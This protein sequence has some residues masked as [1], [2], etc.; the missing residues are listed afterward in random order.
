MTLA[1]AVVV[2]LAGNAIAAGSAAW[3]VRIL[4]SLL[5]IAIA[6]KMFRHAAE[7]EKCGCTLHHEPKPTTNPIALGIAGGLI[8]CFGSLSLVT[9][10]VG[11]GQFFAAVPLVL[12]FALGL[13]VTL[14][15]TAMLTRE[16]GR[17]LLTGFRYS[18]YLAAW[19][20]GI[21][22]VAGLLW[23]VWGIVAGSTE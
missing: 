11:A 18:G 19:L 5:T 23:T 21:A 22:G 10:S 7:Q 1:I 13:G 2:A 3:V 4:A 12:A 20:I 17:R 15:A 9:A 16:V 14:I 8:P 6:I